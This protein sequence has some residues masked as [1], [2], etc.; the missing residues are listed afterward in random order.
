M[1]RLESEIVVTQLRA[2]VQ[3]VLAIE[4]APDANADV[5]RLAPMT[6]RQLADAVEAAGAY[7]R[8]ME[9]RS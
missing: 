6:R 1:D 8:A 3:L 9:V 2:A 7:L 4:Q 5:V